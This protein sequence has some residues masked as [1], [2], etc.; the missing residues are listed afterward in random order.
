MPNQVQA[1]MPFPSF[2]SVNKR[3]HNVTSDLI[4]FLREQPGVPLFN[5]IGDQGPPRAVLV[6]QNCHSGSLRYSV[7]DEHQFDQIAFP[8]GRVPSE[9]ATT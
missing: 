7:V 3:G 4:P 1:K 6:L 2:V 8:L 9:R 5:T